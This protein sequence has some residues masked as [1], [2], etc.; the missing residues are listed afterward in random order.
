MMATRR[1]TRISTTTI[2]LCPYSDDDEQENKDSI[3]HK[4]VVTPNRRKKVQNVSRKAVLKQVSQTAP[5]KR[6]NGTVTF[7]NLKPADLWTR[8]MKNDVSFIGY[9]VT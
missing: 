6:R 3:N 5:K 4:E 1:S 9:L 7:K 2:E 8:A